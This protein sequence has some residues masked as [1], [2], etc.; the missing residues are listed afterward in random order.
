MSSFP[1]HAPRP[2]AEQ[3]L[4][5]VSVV[6]DRL[7]SK[8]DALARD[9]HTVVVEGY[10]AKR[11]SIAA[12][13][14]RLVPKRGSSTGEADDQPRRS[15]VQLINSMQ[16]Y[17]QAAAVVAAIGTGAA[18]EAA[19]PAAVDGRLSTVTPTVQ[20]GAD[21]SHAIAALDTAMVRVLQQC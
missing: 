21:A 17:V 13:A 12:E 20:A 9:V 19:A 11:A 1:G 16:Q 4:Q 5:R 3:V 7:M 6:N 15:D 18:A 8:Y 14:N 10:A 2:S